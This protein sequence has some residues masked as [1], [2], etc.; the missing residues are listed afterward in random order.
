[1]DK[2]KHLEFMERRLNLQR[3]RL[4]QRMIER[5]E[6]PLTDSAKMVLI[7]EIVRLITGNEYLEFLPPSVRHRR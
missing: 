1:M 3:V 6:Y 5:P 7:Y 4:L 2:A